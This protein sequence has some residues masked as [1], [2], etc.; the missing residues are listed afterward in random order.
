MHH[1]IHLYTQCRPTGYPVSISRI[2]F[3]RFSVH[4]WL[5][6]SFLSPFPFL[7]NSLIH[8][9]SSASVVIVVYTSPK[10]EKLRS[11]DCS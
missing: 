2:L 6:L 4:N 11:Q 10:G 9:S 1:L 8:N 7:P 3:S 5:P